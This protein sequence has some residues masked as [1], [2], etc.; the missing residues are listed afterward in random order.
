MTVKEVSLT[1]ILLSSLLSFRRRWPSICA[2]CEEDE[3]TEDCPGVARCSNMC[4]IL[5]MAG[6]VIGD[7]E[8]ADICTSSG[9]YYSII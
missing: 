6:E 7:E 4:T 5:W 3:G 8:T 9:Y 2:S 1:I